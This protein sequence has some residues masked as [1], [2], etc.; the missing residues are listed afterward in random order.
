[1]LCADAG[2]PPLMTPPEGDSRQLTDGSLAAIDNEVGTSCLK[3]V[4]R[5]WTI[6]WP[7][8]AASVHRHHVLL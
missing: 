5:S 3:A 6:I 7:G 4:Q 8:E 2:D 1:M